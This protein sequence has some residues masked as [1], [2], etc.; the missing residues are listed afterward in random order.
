MQQLT[1]AL[2]AWFLNQF[3]Y[4]HKPSMWEPKGEI[5]VRSAILKVWDKLPE[6]FGSRQIKKMVEKEARAHFMDTTVMAWMRKLRNKGKI[7]YECIN[8]QDSIYR[9]L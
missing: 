3:P 9:K 2:S 6:T 4:G 5:S 7:N 1:G 8:R